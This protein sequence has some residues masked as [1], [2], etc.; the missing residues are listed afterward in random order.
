MP[1]SGIDSPK[2]LRS[3]AQQGIFISPEDLP[4]PP[5]AL[6]F[7]G[8]GAQYGGMGRDLYD[9]FPVIREWMDRAAAAADFDILDLMFHDQED[10]P[11]EDPLAA[12]G[13][14]RHGARH[15]PLPDHS[16][17]PPRGHGRP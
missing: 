16:R 12:A 3:L 17:N 11:S 7:P 15:G 9:T 14:V 13:H 8:Q 4:L 6:V 5:L 10:E 2:V 1:K